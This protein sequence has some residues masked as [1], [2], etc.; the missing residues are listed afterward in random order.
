[1]ASGKK[2]T[3]AHAIAI[4]AGL[5]VAL[6]G[7]GIAVAQN[8]DLPNVGGI[9]KDAQCG[10]VDPAGSPVAFGTA[11]GGPWTQDDLEF[12]EGSGLMPGG[13]VFRS[14]A[15]R[16]LDARALRIT[17]DLSKSETTSLGYFAIGANVGPVSGDAAAADPA[18]ITYPGAPDAPQA[19]VP[20]QGFKWLIGDQVPTTLTTDQR[21]SHLVQVVVPSGSY[22][23]ITDWV[24]VPNDYTWTSP[25]QQVNPSWAFTAEPGTIENGVF[26]PAADDAPNFI[27]IGCETKPDNETFEPT[28]AT[29]Q[30]DTPVSLALNSEPLP[31]ELVAN[32]GELPQGTTFEYITAPDTAKP[33][34][35]NVVIKVTYPDTTFDELTV[36]V[37]VEAPAPS[38]T[39]ASSTMSATPESSSPASQA[40][41][42]PSSPVSTTSGTSQDV[43]TALTK[44]ATPSETKVPTSP[45]TS[46]TTTTITTVSPVSPASSTPVSTPVSTAVSPTPVSTTV[47][48]P[49][50]TTVSP[51]VS[52]PSQATSPSTRPTKVTVT[53]TETETT[54]VTAS[55]TSKAPEPTSST[56]PS[57]TFADRLTPEPVDNPEKVIAGTV[58][59]PKR[60][61]K[62]TSSLPTLT[63]FT[64]K[65]PQPDFAT[66]GDK[67]T[68]IVITYPDGSIDEVAITIPVIAK[69]AEPAPQP[70]APNGS[71]WKELSPRCQ[72]AII[73]GGVVGGLGILLAVVSQL[74]IPALDAQVRALNTQIQQSLGIFNPQV[75]VRADNASSVIGG[76]LGA[77]IFLA[78]LGT[79]LGAC[80]LELESS[81][82]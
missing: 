75:A 7:G 80:K 22:I 65:N 20:A 77:T 42:A 62:A 78:S 57:G 73:G 23:P 19:E 6:V 53:T 71:S 69:D 10:A 68:T 34:D 32:A 30:N 5:S 52:T 27:P 54:P 64:F 33:G 4:S 56:V 41:S 48:T 76:V 11:K 45:Q 25:G 66:P 38:T 47:S 43:S 35:Q 2:F 55:P 63:T 51:T 44:P 14:Y 74:R 70:A 39:P 50:S 1:M 3:R 24:A 8:A 81:S 9:E 31:E 18:T 28:P 17:I 13:K 12:W 15:V 59:D 40:E 36:P 82:K 21:G 60:Y 26:V 29:G 61:I 16:N 49:V 79:T 72:N 67:T 58:P 37:T 46:V